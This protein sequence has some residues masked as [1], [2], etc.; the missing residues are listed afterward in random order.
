MNTIKWLSHPPA[1]YLGR[2][3]L[4]TLLCPLPVLL[5][6]DTSAA[7][8]TEPTP[9]PVT[10]T[11]DNQAPSLRK[12]NP[13]WNLFGY[14][15]VNATNTPEGR[16]L[17]DGM[18]SSQDEQDGTPVYV[19][20]HHMFTSGPDIPE[21]FKATD[22]SLAER[23]THAKWGS[24][25]IYRE[26]DGKVVYNFTVVNAII[27]QWVTKS[28]LTPLME[29]GFMPRDLSSDPSMYPGLPTETPNGVK[30]ESI[31]HGSYG[32]DPGSY[33]VGWNLPPKD[34]QKWED[35]CFAFAKHCQS[36]YPHSIDTWLWQ[37]WNE[38]NDGNIYYKNQNV[39]SYTKLY[40]YAARGIKRALPHA[41]IGGPHVAGGAYDF[42]SQFIDNC[43]NPADPLPLDFVAFHAK[44]NAEMDG[45]H[46]R[47]VISKH[48]TEIDKYFAIVEK[49]NQQYQKN[50]PVI[51]GES[52]PDGMAANAYNSASDGGRR[53]EY[54]NLPIYASYTAA[55]FFRKLEL[56][57]KRNIQLDGAVTWSF[58]FNTPN[59]TLFSGN[60]QLATF[61]IDLPVKHAFS[62]LNLL[63]GEEISTTVIDHK[64]PL[65]AVVNEGVRGAA[66]L[67]S[68]ASR[69]KEKVNVLLWHYHDSNAP[70][71]SADVSLSVNGLTGGEV[72]IREHRV[73]HD[74]GNPYRIWKTLPSPTKK[75]PKNISPD[76]KKL[77][78]AEAKNTLLPPRAQKVSA[79]GSLSMQVN[80]PRQSVILLEIMP[81]EPN[82]AK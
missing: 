33:T 54:R 60:R 27:D 12:V 10:V 72:T 28:K 53:Y 80:L 24:T 15:E 48:L 25:S 71:P 38:P 46:P 61:D 14:D 40:K 74:H 18:R 17:L 44:G 4:T 55:S 50:W 62:M 19:R 3:L 65:Q 35:L 78:V 39:E 43:M 30:V 5:A 67:G 31:G 77:L 64:Q 42:F 29:I 13:I 63:R 58:V 41:K 73:D 56:A 70:G 11:V 51:I 75:S 69:E 1:L 81:S 23:N 20:A 21:N 82:P 6:Q 34:Y 59:T 49:K 45:I 57:R 7:T 52:D 26:I 16:E 37:V 2:I 8:D 22:A 36:R 9:I 68:Y 47:M 32:G 76:D 79:D 66:D